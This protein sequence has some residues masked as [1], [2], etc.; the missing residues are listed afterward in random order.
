[1]S[2]GS[3]V[4]RT[5]CVILLA[6]LVANGCRSARVG[7]G[8]TP[9]E[10]IYELRQEKA[11][12]TV[13]LEK[14]EQ[15]IA[16][17]LEQIDQL[18]SEGAVRSVHVQGVDPGDL[19]RLVEV[20]L[21]RYSGPLDDDGDGRDDHV[22]LYVKTL[23]QRGRFLPVVGRGDIQ[24]V[25]LA[26]ARPPEVI[27]QLGL[28]PEAFEAVYRSGFM[29]T[30]YLFDVPILIELG[31]GQHQAAVKVAVT[32]AA[33]GAVVKHQIPVVLHATP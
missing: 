29:G 15:D 28:G 26:D 7:G 4:K 17:R 14:L 22:R 21:G 11:A 3:G 12:L 6:V 27:G 16:R 8:D 23:D 10:V 31:N 33:T 32:D 13:R 5:T 19:P 24:V 30:H 20:Q 1:M 25:L 9:D 18:V 2:G